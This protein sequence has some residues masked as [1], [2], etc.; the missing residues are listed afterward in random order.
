MLECTQVE[1]RGYEESTFPIVWSKKI[2]I[3][4]EDN[5]YNRIIIIEFQLE[6]WNTANIYHTPPSL[7]C[8]SNKSRILANHDEVEGFQQQWWNP[9]KGDGFSIPKIFTNNVIWLDESIGN[10]NI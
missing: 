6:L 9:Y 3:R 2:I 8:N 1:F 4:Q 5:L 7:R 10:Y